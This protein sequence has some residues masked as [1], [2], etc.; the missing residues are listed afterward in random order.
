MSL[1][2]RPSYMQPKGAD[3][4]VQETGSTGTKSLNPFAS[5]ESE[6]LT[7]GVGVPGTAGALSGSSGKPSG[8]ISFL[9]GLAK[10]V[11]KPFVKA[12]VTGVAAV[13]S[14]VKLAKGD[15]EGANRVTEEGYDVGNFGQVKPAKIGTDVSEQINE[16]KS[17]FGRNTLDTVGTGAEIATT[18]AGGGEGA[19]LVKGAGNASLRQL[20]KAGLKEGAALGSVG[21]ASRELQNEDATVGS[22]ASSAL[23]EG[24]VGG[25]LGIAIPLA[26]SLIKPGLKKAGS[27]W[28]SLMDTPT[29][30][31]LAKS[32][33]ESASSG[34]LSAKAAGDVVDGAAAVSTPPTQRFVQPSPKAVPLDPVVK[35]AAQSAGFDDR[36]IDLVEG[37]SQTDKDSFKRMVKQAE[38][39][40]KSFGKERP[41]SIA[42]ETIMRRAEHIAEKRKEV[43]KSLGEIVKS[44]PKDP[45]DVSKARGS[46]FQKLEEDGVQ[47]LDDGKLDFSDTRYA[48]DSSGQ[49]MIQQLY[50]DLD[51]S[52]GMLTPQRIQRIRQ[53]LFDDLDLGAKKEALSGRIESLL[54]QTRSELDAPLQ[55][56]SPEYAKYSKEYAKSSQAL[57]DFYQLLGKK[58]TGASDEALKLRAGEVGARIGS[59]ASADTVRVLDGLD[60]TAKELGGEFDDDIARQFFF[61]EVL[62]D[63]YKITQPRS[64][65]GGI[66]RGVEGALEK[67]GIVADVAQGKILSAGGKI[68]GKV[69]GRTPE[70][71]QAALKKLIGL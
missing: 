23:T 24:A 37:A 69:L 55:G 51:L 70:K 13:D 16:G 5:L 54:T 32:S 50:D 49:K 43:G 2:K 40:S 20:A 10:G 35:K 11:A 52:D 57:A 44:L 28:R 60:R 18:L 53:R 29:A 62:N 14:A 45:I 56:L 39:A 34:I 47:M 21:G 46:F 12:G 4:V 1:I 58:F 61:S 36:V 6:K 42:G 22:V 66:E 67:A 8:I 3:S 17:A 65:Q 26:S 41:V 9:G 71:Q 38:I 15:V 7:K 19:A 63:L 30:S 48:N 59:N 33:D 31:T 27:V 25:A 64:F 68:A